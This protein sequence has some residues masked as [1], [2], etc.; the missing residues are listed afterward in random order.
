MRLL[1][2]VAPTVKKSV[3]QARGLLHMKASIQ[4]LKNDRLRNR[5]LTTLF[6]RPP[7]NAPNLDSFRES[8][9]NTLRQRPEPEQ[10]PPFVYTANELFR[11][12]YAD[13]QP[14]QE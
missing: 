3:A 4:S 9:F 6:P 11:Q 14:S 7:P 12:F 10:W 8:L 5:W 1:F 13:H 2:T